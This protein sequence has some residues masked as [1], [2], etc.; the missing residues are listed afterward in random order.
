MAASRFEVR[1]FPPGVPSMIRRAAVLSLVV[2]TWVAS[3]APAQVKLEY[4]FTEGAATT[5][6]VDI[7]IHQVLTINGMD[8]ETDSEQT[9]VSGTSIGMRAADG[10]LPITNTIDSLRVHISIPGA[11]VDYDT[12]DP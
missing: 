5:S 10:A 12:A 9:A 1:P 8:V 6:K 4:K 11:V 3:P 2:C 7:K